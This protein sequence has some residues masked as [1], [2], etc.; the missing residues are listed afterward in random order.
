MTAN[1]LTTDYLADAQRS[2]TPPTQLAEVAARTVDLAATTYQG[3][4]LTRPVF[5][6]HGEFARL[7]QDVEQLHATLTGLPGRLFG[8]DLAA[9]AR[10]VGTTPEQT[11]A[12]LRGSSGT[13]TR[14][15]RADLYREPARFA[16]ME[17]N[18]GGTVG[19]LDNALLNTAFLS[20]PLVADFV[21]AH[22]LAYVDTMA[23]LADTIRAECGIADGDRPLIAVADWPQSWLDLEPQ[24]RYS[25]AQLTAHGLDVVACHLG[26]LSV[27][28]GHVWLDGADRPVEVIYRVFMIEDLL[29]PQAPELIEPVLRAAER[30]EVRI[31][32][33]MDADLYGSKGALALLSDEANRH[34][35]SADELASLDRIL[36]WTRMARSGQVTV[37]GGHA[38]L[39]RYALEQQ[40]DLILKPTLLH[41]GS[42]VVPGWT[43]DRDEWA[44]RLAAAMNGPFVLQRRIRPVPELFPADDGLEPWVLTWGIF[45]GAGGHIGTW[46]RGSAG[47][48]GGVV[49]MATGAT[50]T[51]CFHEAR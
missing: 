32:A 31:F 16:L 3:R 1:S 19:G 7:C 12:I 28:D 47:H 24:L 23:A 50:A 46:V 29:T 18:M 33:P 13:P 36:P 5:L 9:F 14:L 39:A 30:G 4:C 48:D 45:L 37:D 26:Q 22:G 25:A 38:D 44:G 42:G 15:C 27:R 2:G 49:N 43:V 40:D 35:Y 8:G 11:S 17:V 10:A 21:A 34:L 6:E 41:A 20:Q 51:C